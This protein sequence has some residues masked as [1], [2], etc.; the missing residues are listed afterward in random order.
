MILAE[1][2]T[3]LRKKNGWSQEELAQEMGVSRQ[4]ISKWESAQSTPDLNRILAL[5]KIFDV[6][7]D[8]LLKDDAELETAPI[9][10]EGSDHTGTGYGYAL[11]EPEP[12]RNVS[13]EEANEYLKLKA[14]SAGRIAIG[15]MLCILSPITSLMLSMA[16]EEHLIAISENQADGIGIL[17][18]MLMVGA[19]VGLF[20][21]YGMKMSRF[22]YITKEPLETAYGVEGMV[23][24]RMERYNPA[25]MK[26]MI[27]GIL[28]CVLS[29]VPVFIAMIIGESEPLL[30]T[31]T[32]VLL[33]LVAIGVMLIV[34]T[35]IIMEGMKSLLEEGEFSRE[36]K[37]EE[38]RNETIMGAYWLLATAIYLL[39]SF[40]TGRW[41]MTW[42]VWPVAGVGC[43]LLAAILKVIR[44][45]E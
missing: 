24:D 23:R 4:A 38:R 44:S 42:I 9:Y 12:L 14:E 34:R 11:K 30:I 35:S 15:V 40:L 25:H 13:M 5:A 7:T 6:S 8:V 43:G 33:V 27:I 22:D 39:L 10:A 28:L 1:K 17:V 32:A 41:D 29:C 19:A 18:L 20:V 16:Y 31:G 37:R 3:L 2:I 21:Y 45:R 36:N 26:Y